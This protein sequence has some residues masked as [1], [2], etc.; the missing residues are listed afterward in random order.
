V[1]TTG[2]EPVPP[3]CK[4]GA[5]PSELHPHACIAAQK[6]V[7]ERRRT[8]ARAISAL[9]RSSALTTAWPAAR[10][11]ATRCRPSRTTYRSPWRARRTAGA[12]RP[13][14]SH[15][16]GVRERAT[17]VDVAGQRL[18]RPPDRWSATISC[19]RSRSRRWETSSHAANG[20][21]GSTVVRTG[22]VEPPQRVAT[23]LQPAELTGAQRPQ[24]GGR[25]GSNRRRADHDRECSPLTPRPPRNG[26]DRTRTGGLS[27]DKR[28]L[29]ALSYAPTP[30]K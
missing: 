27:P 7:L 12:S 13:S 25:P 30:K 11:A 2:V 6:Q 21:F 18:D 23:G 10:A 19:R 9:R 28:A 20:F 4:R 3:R 26:D 24:E 17:P 16:R 5:L 15:C 8:A 29:S 14:S 22:G 1:E